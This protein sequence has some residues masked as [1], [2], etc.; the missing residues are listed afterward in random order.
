MKNTLESLQRKNICFIANFNKTILFNKIAIELT[1]KDAALNI[2]WV[3]ANKRDVSYLKKFWPAEH[4]LHVSIAFSMGGNS[5][6]GDFKLNELVFGDRVL[7]NEKRWATSYLVGIQEPFY[8][9]I[10]ENSI[11]VCFGETTWAHEVLFHRIVSQKTE[12]NCEY[13]CPHTIRI[14]NGRFAF[15]RDEFQSEFLPVLFD[16]LETEEAGRLFRVEK[17]DYVDMNNRALHAS[18]A[19]RSR[20]G[21]VA[22]YLTGR[23]LRKEDPTSYKNLF[24]YTR[25]KISEEINKELFRIVPFVRINELVGT[26]YVFMPLHKQPEASIDV[27]GRYYEDQYENIKNIWRALPFGWKLAVKEHTNA[28]GDR[29]VAFYRRI[30]KLDNVVLVDSA[31]DSQEIIRHSKLVVTVSGTAAY[32]AALMGKP[33]LTLAPCFFNA[34]PMCRKIGLDDLRSCGSLAELVATEDENASVGRGLAVREIIRRSARGLVADPV[35]NPSVLSP[36]NMSQVVPAFNIAI[37]YVHEVEKAR[38]VTRSA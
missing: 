36:E 8:N 6:I 12:L 37:E 3:A 5:P 38:T 13:L 31:A 21:K 9:F 35:S 28:I 33:A 27:I 16:D 4:I 34:L 10:R 30:R 15:F 11:K 32:E 2:F 14:P 23:S 29:S 17:P 24:A 26:P 7:R 20:L 19:V 25:I 18:R 1:N 22:R